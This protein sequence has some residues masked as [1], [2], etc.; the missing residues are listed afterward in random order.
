MIDNT[1][2]TGD[3]GDYIRVYNSDYIVGYDR[4]FNWCYDRDYTGNYDGDYKGTMIM[5]SLGNIPCY[6]GVHS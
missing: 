1:C 6:Q 4:D 5:I 3:Y 2:Y